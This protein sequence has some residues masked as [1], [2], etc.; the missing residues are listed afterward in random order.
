MKLCITSL[1][2]FWYLYWLLTGKYVPWNWISVWYCRHL[3]WQTMRYAAHKSIYRSVNMYNEKKS[4]SASHSLKHVSDAAYR[5]LSNVTHLWTFD[6][7]C[8]C[9]SSI[10]TIRV[11]SIFT[12]IK[13]NLNAQYLWNNSPSNCF[14]AIRLQRRYKWMWYVI[15]QKWN[16]CMRNVLLNRVIKY[17]VT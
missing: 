15:K 14:Q 11:T 1:P 8:D 16:M 5:P 13:F 2:F 7:L 3:P 10:N 4:I 6:S 12:T 9:T 17:D